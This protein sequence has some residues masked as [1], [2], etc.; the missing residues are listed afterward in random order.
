MQKSW[1]KIILVVALVILALG[2]LA[3]AFLFPTK[4]E[5]ID[6][7]NTNIAGTPV[8]KLNSESLAPVSDGW[9]KYPKWEANDHR[10]FISDSYLY[11][12]KEQKILS[13]EPGTEIDGIPIWWLQKYN[14]DIRSATVALDDPDG[15][16]FSNIMEYRN[17]TDPSDSNSHPSYLV[18]LRL[19]SVDI[20]PFRIRFQTYNELDGEKIFQLN[21]LDLPANKRTRL[22]KIGDKF[23]G[24]VVTHFEEKITPKDIGGSQVPVNESVLTLEKPEIGFKI[25][26]VYNQTKDSPE[27]SVHFIMLLPGKTKQEIIVKRGSELELPQERG[28]KYLLLRAEE[29]EKDS[30]YNAILRS[31]SDPAKEIVVPKVTPA[32]LA[33]VPT[34]PKLGR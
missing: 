13:V 17:G 12:R 22:V 8:P 4:Q 7:K 25:D 6:P 24:Y 3:L 34:A 32:D 27:Y 9:F 29:K 11:D 16:G 19:S 2:A 21:L 20:I 15:D 10:L 14:I 26:L 5:I 23:E 1:E 31:P 18:L 33:E 28:V 30:G